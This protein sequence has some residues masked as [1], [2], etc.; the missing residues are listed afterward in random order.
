MDK[1]AVLHQVF[2]DRRLLAGT[3]LSYM[4]GIKIPKDQEEKLCFLDAINDDDKDTDNGG[5]IQDDLTPVLF[6]VKL[7]AKFHVYKLTVAL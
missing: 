3:T 1:M 7:V 4:A 5:P 6:D 2:L